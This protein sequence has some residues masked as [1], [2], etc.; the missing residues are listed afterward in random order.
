MSVYV[1]HLLANHFLF[2]YFQEL[3]KQ[4]HSCIYSL[5]LRIVV[6]KMRC[7]NRFIIFDSS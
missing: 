2:G 6:F 4:L 7:D 3:L 5:D 1:L